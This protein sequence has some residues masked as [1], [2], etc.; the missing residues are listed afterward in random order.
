[1]NELLVLVGLCII[2]SGRVGV[3]NILLLLKYKELCLSRLMMILVGLCCR[4]CLVVC[5]M[6]WLLVSKCVFLLLIISMLICLS[7][8]VRVAVLLL[9]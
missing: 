8:L 3:V 7:T 2:F 5:E 9:I 6:L 1:M 4:I